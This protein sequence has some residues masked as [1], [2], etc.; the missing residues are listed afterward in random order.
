MADDASTI[1]FNRKKIYEKLDYAP[2]PSDYSSKI[3]WVVQQQV[4]ATNGVH[5]VDRI[6]KLKEYPIFE[7]PVKQVSANKLML[8]I[9]NGWGRWLVAGANKG[10][11]PIGIDLRL[12]FCQT[13]RS[14][15]KDLNK[16][17]YSVVADLE[18]LPFQDNVFDLVWSFSV[19]QHTHYQRLTNCLQHINRILSESGF[20]YLEFPNKNGIRNKYGPLKESEKEKGD[21][22][23]WC[24]RYYTPDEYKEIF[25]KFLSDF[26]YYNHSF[27]GIGVLKEDLKYVSFKNKVLSALSLACSALTQVIPPLKNY[28]DSLYI[29]SR[30]KSG[31]DINSGAGLESRKLFFSNV[32][33]NPSDNLNVVSL[34]RCPKYGTALELS[35]DRKKIISKEAGICYPIENEIPILIVSEAKSVG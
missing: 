12:E 2:E 16:V 22:N 33:A 6:G 7:L 23:S 34:L 27:L 8:D 1:E 17:G 20:T 24:V 29:Q 4:A 28:S 15:L 35:P 3:P 32:K 19:I 31:P 5:Y 30:K 11:I 9:G 26:S 25:E 18:N 14:V 10:Y 13:A 21:Y